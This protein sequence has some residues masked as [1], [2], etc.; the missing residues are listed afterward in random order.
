MESAPVFHS[1][2]V[3][4]RHRFLIEAFYKQKWPDASIRV[5]SVTRKGDVLSAELLSG[6][7]QPTMAVGEP[8]HDVTHG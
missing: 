7:A 8:F 4:R 1:T 5:D 6:G 2:D 3:Y